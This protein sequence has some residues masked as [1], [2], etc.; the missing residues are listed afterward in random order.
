MDKVDLTLRILPLNTELQIDLPL[1]TT[2]AQL[3][4]KLLDNATQFGFPLTDREGNRFSYKLIDQG[5]GR[6][7]P[8]TESLGQAGIHA[9]ST[10]LLAPVLVGG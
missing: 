4:Q 6:D 2:T 7:L 8:L 1:N 5:N 3:L 9:G 10:I